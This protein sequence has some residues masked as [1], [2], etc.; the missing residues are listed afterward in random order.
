LG[1]ISYTWL[2]NRAEPIFSK[3]SSSHIS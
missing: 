2:L 1:I 3:D